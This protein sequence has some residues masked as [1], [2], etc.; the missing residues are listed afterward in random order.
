MIRDK[1]LKTK[2]KIVY[3]AFK[4]FQSES[5]EK[6]SVSQ[7]SNQASIGKS[8]FY[9]YFKSKDDLIWYIIEREIYNLFSLF[10]GFMTRGYK[11]EDIDHVVDSIVTYVLSHK[12]ELQLV[13][14]IKFYSYLGKERIQNVYYE[15]NGIIG[16]IYAW[17]EKGKTIGQLDILD[18]NFT[19]TRKYTK[20]HKL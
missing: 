2:N 7:I 18:V 1:G 6:V 20:K 5:I 12:E 13:N 9:S 14:D 16:P 11:S 17:L 4:L 19:R 8:T 3:E 15:E 10:D